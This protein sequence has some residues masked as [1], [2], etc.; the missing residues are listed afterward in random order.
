MHLQFI[1]KCVQRSSMRSSDCSWAEIFAA[2]KN[3][4]LHSTISFWLLND[5]FTMHSKNIVSWKI[6]REAKNKFG[7]YKEHIKIKCR[8]WNFAREEITKWIDTWSET[9]TTP[10][11]TILV[12]QCHTRVHLGRA[13]I[14]IL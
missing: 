5:S 12:S 3:N 10:F 7:T 8:T 11:F 14:M 1:S 13:C 6:L 4:P 9:S 2:Q